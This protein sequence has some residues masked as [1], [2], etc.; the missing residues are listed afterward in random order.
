MNNKLPKG[1]RL[2]L[3]KTASA[4]G[5]NSYDTYDLRGLSLGKVVLLLNLLQT[6]AA[7]G[8]PLAEELL[9]AFGNVDQRQTCNG[10]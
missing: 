7:Q 6:S 4:Q 9:S 5:P 10:K 1:S 3:V 8:N 2:A